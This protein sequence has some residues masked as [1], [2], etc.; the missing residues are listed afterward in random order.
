V[1]NLKRNLIKEF[2]MEIKP[3][4]VVTFHYTVRDKETGEIYD[5]SVE[6]GQPLKVLIGA[7]QI[8]PGLEKKLIG[9]KKGDT[10]VI[11]VPAEEAYGAKDPNLIQSLPRE[12]FEGVELEK[13]LPLQ[14]QTP[15]GDVLYLKVV[16]FD[17]KSVTVDFN[18]PL[19]GRNLVFEVKIEDVREAT[20]E[21]VAHGHAH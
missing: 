5:S 10:A 19:A 11:E 9:L 4:T 3:N 14:M 1:L 13:G 20:P 7:N 18:H 15:E 16:D 17:D 2:I 8:I 6:R 12:Y 21:E